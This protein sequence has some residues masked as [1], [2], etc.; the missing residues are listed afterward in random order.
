MRKGFIACLIFAFLGGVAYAEQA[1]FDTSFKTAR[2]SSAESP[3]D[4]GTLLTGKGEV[5]SQGVL[6]ALEQ[7]APNTLG[8]CPDG[9]ADTFRSVNRIVVRTIPPKTKFE[10]GADVEVEVRANCRSMQ[11]F[12]DI[13]K[14]SNATA[15]EWH[16][17]TSFVCDGT[18]Q[19]EPRVFKATFKLQN[20]EGNHAVRA[21]LRHQGQPGVCATG[22]FVDNDDLVFF[23]KRRVVEEGKVLWTFTT[24]GNVQS[25]PVIDRGTVVVATR[26][27]QTQ[28][29]GLFT[30]EVYLLGFDGTLKKRVT[31]EGAIP[32][33][34]VVSSNDTIYIGTSGLKSGTTF[35]RLHAFTFD[36]TER[37]AFNGDQ[38]LATPALA[39]DGTV[40]IGQT[41]NL[42]AVNPDGT[43]KFRTGPLEG[44]I[45]PA[46][47]PAVGQDGTVYVGTTGASNGITGGIVQISGR[48]YAIS[49]QG[50]VLWQF[51]TLGEVN[52][53]PAI[54]SD[55]TIYAGSVGL[56]LSGGKFEG[57]FH[58]LTPQGTLKWLLTLD[59]RIVTS[60]VIGEDGTIYTV[61]TIGGVHAIN[62]N[63]TIKWKVNTGRTI[64]KFSPAIG[65]D[66]TIYVGTNGRLFA[67][68]PDGT[69][70]WQVDTVGSSWPTVGDEV[71]FI[72]VAGTG[73]GPGFIQTISTKSR[74][75]AISSWPKFG[76]DPRNTGNIS[77]P[78]TL[79]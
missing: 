30:G 34:P 7:N 18:G 24:L 25:C 36:G 55:G 66:G 43:L 50:K 48:L 70:R 29:P 5:T 40:Y 26:G 38:V 65:S 19:L 59:D 10:P 79:R 4:S 21:T 16:P 77:T 69:I 12:V 71:V 31:V 42:T 28:F 56:R 41:G 20:V 37:W 27:Q 76:H 23:V 75:L 13:L 35:G 68:N 2:C 63:G 73:F 32:A 33:S 11:D 8:N 3:C 17:V 72:G 49:S 1:T 78:L 45:A 46:G 53:Q 54:G 57:R 9:T 61:T 15:P 14:A 60:P 74:G 67:F 44:T 51:N 6:R 52:I 39:N 47:A 64:V 62:P 58:A 22:P